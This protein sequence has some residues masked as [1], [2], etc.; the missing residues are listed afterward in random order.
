MDGNLTTE[1]R[2]RQLV[3]LVRTCTDLTD[4]DIKILLEVSHSLPF[5]SKLENGDTYINV[6][7]RDGESMVVA[8]YRNPH[9]DLYKRDI[10]G[11]IE[12]KEDEPAV[13]RALEQG[14]SGRGLIGL[15]DEGRIVVRH[16]VSPILNEQQQVCGSLTSEYLNSDSDTEPIRIINKEGRSGI[17]KVI[18]NLQDGFLIFNEVGICTFAN[19]KA[20]ELYQ[21]IGYDCEIIGERYEELQLT[22]HDK[23]DIMADNHLLKDEINIRGCLIEECI[24]AIWEDGNYLGVAIIMRDKTRIRQLENEIEYRAALVHEV[25]HRVK[26]NLQTIIS[27]VGLEAAKT[28]DPDVKAFAR[29]ITRHI[30]SMNVTYELLART[31]SETLGAKEVLERMIE[32]QLDNRRVC[33][34]PIH[35]NVQ[36]DD[37]N[38]TANYASTVALIVNEL[39]QNSM[40]YAFRQC[41]EGIICI[42][43]KKEK[44][45]AWITVLDNG[46]GFEAAKEIGTGSGLGLKLVESLVKSSLKGELIIDSGK[47]GTVVRFSVK[48]I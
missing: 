6:L 30:S 29:V 47:R 44:D 2:D 46:C 40:K 27:L 37:L 28:K 5:I 8:Q 1:V 22:H 10:I 43:I 12:K 31:G 38:L 15:I 18:G 33:D 39:I 21:K 11:E 13:Y 45:G 14:I 36:G 42:R 24:S 41:L 26:N 17:D 16:T 35:I 20:K 7:T 9:C 3:Q 25:H 19:D 23:K 32:S 34:C 48:N 4:A